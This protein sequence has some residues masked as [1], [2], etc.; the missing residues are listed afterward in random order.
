[1]DCAA[2]TIDIADDLPT[3]MTWIGDSYTSALSG[4]TFNIYAGTDHFSLTGVSIPVGISTF[5]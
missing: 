2:K 3:G 5:T 1:V 4:G